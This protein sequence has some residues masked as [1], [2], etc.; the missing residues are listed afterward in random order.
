M[1]VPVVALA[2]AGVA[3]AANGGFAPQHA[4]SPNAHRIN[5]VYYVIF[6]FTAAIFVI[7]ETVLVVLI[8]KYRSRGRSREVEGA[9]VHGNTR[10]ELIW[11]ALPAVILCIIGIVVFIELPK[12]ANVP[13]ASASDRLN[14]TVEGHQYYWQFDYPNGA[15]SIGDLHVP[16]N[17]V[18]YLT[19]VS[20]DVAHSWWIPQLGGKT[21]AI[22][23]RTNHTWFKADREG[24]YSGQCAE[25]CG[26]FHEA[27]HATVIAT[28]DAE[29]AAWVAGAAKNELGRE[30]FQ[31]VC[32]T[33]HGMKGQGGYG[34]A[35]AD[36]SIIV[37]PAGLDAIVRNGRGNMPAVGATWTA[38][39]MH[40]LLVYLKT[41]VYTGGTAT[42]GG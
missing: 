5:A 22:P 2:T 9:Q 27:M 30:E 31:G 37:Q 4:H 34:P 17:K 21:D 13:A 1:M 25:F 18:V 38:A 8:L 29:Y 26:I 15:R 24:T 6:G 20:P 39:Q 36:N 19:I 32:A 7:V 41:H 11:T 28:S 23:G 42:S 40:A 35:I 10:L 33:C 16:A 12:I 14:I 3:A